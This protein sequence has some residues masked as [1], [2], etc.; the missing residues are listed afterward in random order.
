MTNDEPGR[1]VTGTLVGT[2]EI[3]GT[4]AVSLP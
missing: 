1:S 3:D 2:S 4:A